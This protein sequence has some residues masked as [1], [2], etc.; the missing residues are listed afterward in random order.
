MNAHTTI[1][2]SAPAL[3]LK[4]ELATVREIISVHER[5]GLHRDPLRYIESDDYADLLD[6]IGA[7]T[8][9]DALVEQAGTIRAANA[10]S[11]YDWKVAEGVR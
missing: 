4:R 9:C 11:G 5:L 1:A 10:V 8:E 3:R 2:L 7:L 6:A